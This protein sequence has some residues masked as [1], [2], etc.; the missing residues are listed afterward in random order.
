MS[1]LINEL[2]DI[3]GIDTISLFP[4]PIGWWVVIALSLLSLF[5]LRKRL[6]FLRSWKRD[7]LIKLKELEENLSLT[8]S[9][10]TLQLLSEYVRRIALKRFPRK[11]CAGLT[12][13]AWLKWLNEHDPKQFDWLGK[14]ELLLNAPYAPKQE[15]PTADIKELIQAIRYWVV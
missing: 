12:G 11:E 14:A 1:P 4:L 6:K 15:I 13:K 7:T 2:H 9:K 5:F 10:E 8:T 3:E